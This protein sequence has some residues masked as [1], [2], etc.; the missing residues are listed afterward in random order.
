MKSLLKA[1]MLR[2]RM[3]AHDGLNLEDLSASVSMSAR[4]YTSHGGQILLAQGVTVSPHCAISAEGGHVSIGSGSYLNRGV[5]IGAKSS[6]TLGKMCA[7]GPYVV[8]VDT[9]KDQYARV[10]G[11]DRSDRSQPVLLRDHVWV[12]ANSTLVAGV[13]VGCG[14]VVAAGSVVTK[15]VPAMSIVGGVPA[16]VIG[17]VEPADV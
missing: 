6:V 15:D 1:L 7:L 11:T 4:F 8:V 13:E 14:A 17:A 3:L 2:A 16:K 5:I 9:T 12:G 10:S